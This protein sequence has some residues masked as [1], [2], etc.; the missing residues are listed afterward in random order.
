VADVPE[1][2]ILVVRLV[3]PAHDPHDALCMIGLCR[4]ARQAAPSQERNGPNLSKA[5]RRAR[6]G[7]SR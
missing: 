6:N 3:A 1:E 2:L 7:L 4:S 5:S